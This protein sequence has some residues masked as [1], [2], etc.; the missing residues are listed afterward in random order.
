MTASL[1]SQFNSK[2]QSL[3]GA[4]EFAQFFRLKH[5]AEAFGRQQKKRNTRPR[6]DMLKSFHGSR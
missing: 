2:K 3:D 6:T 1:S 5:A 4:D